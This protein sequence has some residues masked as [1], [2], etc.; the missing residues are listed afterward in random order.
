VGDKTFKNHLDGYN[1]VPFLKGEV[2]EA[3]RHEFFYFSDS[4]DLLA[5][6]Y[7]DWK[8][9]FKTIQGNLFTG[10]QES[11]NVPLVT[12]LRQDPWERYQDQSMLYGKWWG[13]HLWV[14]IPSVAIVGQF[15]QSFVQYPPSQ[16]SG[17]LSIEKALH[18][19]E[20]GTE[21]AGK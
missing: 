3:P 10:T 5:V 18:Q 13:E 15:L 8:I 11:T 19:L 16:V 4:A 17:S 7:D 9:S 6:R 14:M 20:A 2:A 12:N 1:F 21:G